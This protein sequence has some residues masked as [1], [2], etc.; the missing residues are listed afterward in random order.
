MDALL[1]EIHSTWNLC[2][3]T[4]A[5][6]IDPKFLLTCCLDSGNVKALSVNVMM[7]SGNADRVI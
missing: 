4:I 7:Y 3:L 6:K 5:I 2:W 1:E